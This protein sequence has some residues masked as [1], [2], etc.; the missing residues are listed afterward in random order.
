MTFRQ[1]DEEIGL[2][3]PLDAEGTEQGPAP[4][5]TRA[6]DPVRLYF[7]EM[8]KVRLLTARQEVEIGRRIED[9]QIALRRALAGVP[10]AVRRLLDL[11]EAVR[12]GRTPG[13]EMLL[14]PAGG[15]VDGRELKRL[16]RALGRIRRLEAEVVRLTESLTD[17]RLGAASRANYTKWIEA[18]RE[19]IQTVIAEL[20]LD[21]ALIDRLVAEVRAVAERG[22]EGARAAG[23]TPAV[24][25]SRLAEIS[26]HDAAVRQAKREL[27]EANLRLVVSI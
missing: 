1:N 19:S 27:T 2:L 4:E 14:P 24:L 15:E 18:N 26:E 23:L 12:G 10:L 7:Q 25:R 11:G 13:D 22:A 20:P 9:A 6:E 3:E 8:G 21:P 5:E 17:R 16:Y